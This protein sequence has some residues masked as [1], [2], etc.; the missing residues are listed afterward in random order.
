MRK[1]EYDSRKSRHQFIA[2]TF[3]NYLSG[4][5]LNIGGGGEKHL[6]SYLEPQEYIEVDIDGEP[7]LRI[8]LDTEMPLPI[9][10][11]RFD[12][13][14]CTEV[15][16][17]LENLHEVFEELLRI[18]RRYVIISVP[19]AL[20]AFRPYLRRI[21]YQ[22]EARSLPGE[23]L[24]RYSKFYGLPLW[25]PQDRHRWFFS[26]TEAEYFFNYHTNTLGYKIVEEYPVSR[27]AESRVER[28]VR[29]LVRSFFGEIVLKD[30]FFSTYWCVIEKRE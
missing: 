4:S 29:F 24:G 3:G 17:H 9:N 15:L 8:D 7:D 12:T 19:N 16:E 27:Y 21:V 2:R 5:I 18:S 28:F 30:W 10:S 25:K 6:L 20:L 11:G 1:V 14:L 22:P 26:Y 13:V 23:K